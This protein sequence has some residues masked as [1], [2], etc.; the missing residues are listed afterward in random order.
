MAE[1]LEGINR[2]LKET[3][4]QAKAAANRIKELEANLTSL[5]NKYAKG[6][7]PTE[8]GI[9]KFQQRFEQTGNVPYRGRVGGGAYL[10][11]GAREEILPI[12]RELQ[13]LR[14][15]SSELTR[16]FQE[17]NK[18]INALTIGTVSKGTPELRQVTT[19][20]KDANKE[21]VLTPAEK[22]RRDAELQRANREA[23]LRFSQ[24]E[25]GISTSNKI[26]DIGTSARTAQQRIIEKAEKQVADAISKRAQQEQKQ[27]EEDLAAW[28]RVSDAR[29]AEEADIEAR[30]AKQNAVFQQYL[31]GL[32]KQA[33]QAAQRAQAKTDKEEERN[34]KKLADAIQKEADARAK[35]AQKVIE[36]AQEQE[37][38][39]T[40]IQQKNPQLYARASQLGFT[41]DKESF[42]V[43]TTVEGSTGI[44][45]TT[46][47]YKEL[48]GTIQKLTVTQNK[49]NKILN[50][51]QKR[52]RDLGSAIVRDIGEV[53]KWSIAV[54]AVYAP[55]QKV[56]ELTT[57]M[58]DNESKLADI[59]IILGRSH[60]Q[61]GEIFRNAAQAAAATGESING[62]IEGYTLAYRATGRYTNEI[63]RS[64]VAQKLL[65]D[66]LVLSKLSALD[67]AGAMDT[68][69]GALQQLGYNLD[70]GSELVN[71]WVTVSK[72]ANVG[73][74]TLAE[75]FA[76]TSTS[77]QN[78][79]LSI[80]ELNGIIAV[81]AENTTLSATEA[82]N[83]VRAFISGFQTD[84]ARNQLSK[85]GIAM[86]D[87]SGKARSFTDVMYQISDLYQAGV[88]S[89]SQLN[90]IGEAI[91]GGARRGAQVVATIKNLSR[92]QDIATASAN[93]TND[94]YDALG[95]KLQTLQSRFTL[96]GNSFQEL[97]QNLG[98]DGGILSILKL[99]VSV[100]DAAV[101]SLSAITKSAGGIAPL[102]FGGVGAYLYTRSTGALNPKSPGGGVY[103]SAYNF[104]GQNSALFQGAVSKGLTPDKFVSILNSS[105]TRTLTSVLA[106]L[107][108]LMVL[109]QRNRQGE[110]VANQTIGAI[111]GGIGGALITGL[112]PVGAAVGATIG[113][114]FVD[115]VI[116]YQTSFENFFVN[117]FD[118]ATKK[119]TE[120]VKT[121]LERE[122]EALTKE[123]FTVAGGGSEARG[124][125]IS[126][127]TAAVSNF[128]TSFGA[129]LTG[130]GAPTKI[131]PEIAALGLT[132]DVL[133]IQGNR[134]QREFMRRLQELL[135]RATL[136]KDPLGTGPEQQ[137]SPFSQLV[138]KEQQRNA[139]EITRL[140]DAQRNKLRE[141]AI[142]QSITSKE[143]QQGLDQL[144]SGGLDVI[145]VFTAMNDVL[146]ETQTS[147][148]GLSEV[149]FNAT[150]DQREYILQ[151]T[152]EI[153]DLENRIEDP[154]RLRKGE[155][156]AQLEQ[157][158]QDLTQQLN[159][160]V[161]GVQSQQQVNKIKIP[162]VLYFDKELSSRELEIV[163][164]LAKQIQ[165]RELKIAVEEGG[166]DPSVIDKWKQDVEPWFVYLEDRYQ[167]VTGVDQKYFQ[168]A[169]D[170]AEAAGQVSTTTTPFNITTID[171]YR[172]QFL[173]AYQ[174][175]AGFIKSAFP[176]YQFQDQEAQGV[177]FK[178][179][180][181]DVLHLDNLV[182]QLALQELIDVNKKQLDGLYNLPAGANFYVPIQTLQY[183]YNAG[184]NAGGGVGGG[185]FAGTG[186]SSNI[187]PTTEISDAVKQAAQDLRA[188]R[189]DQQVQQLMSEF[190]KAA[191]ELRTQ[192]SRERLNPKNIE[193]LKNVTTRPHADEKLSTTL[194]LDI[195]S[196]TQ[197]MLDGRIVANVIKAYLFEELIQLA[198]AAST[199]NRSL[200][201][202]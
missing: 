145:Q 168:R 153:A 74:D 56:Q 14:G 82:G 201:I 176:Q 38:R 138:V 146:G 87:A 83:A 43:Q 139:A 149:L 202:P 40:S 92:A 28:R 73:V 29:R 119:S 160:Y 61:M 164:N 130:K 64:R 2:Q 171:A 144:S 141:L 189:K 143:Y 173:A 33:Q 41:P 68:L 166:V 51:T 78:A 16:T 136:E 178:E 158:Q 12:L 58:I 122:Q 69:V 186:A 120:G 108:Q 184:L 15:R 46:L 85:F 44:K 187:K 48:D 35:A 72:V 188:E 94:A 163:I 9:S 126:Q 66:S 147:L 11:A 31:D 137:K 21:Y 181:T 107:P 161:Q 55:L 105:L 134:T 89:D 131:T 1:N 22:A 57:L 3:E 75:S 91:G 179:N 197:L 102:L 59:A 151:L 132:G 80:D 7:T 157:R 50:D 148:E 39:F 116:E 150:D 110:N 169:L 123:I 129:I 30:N 47:Q 194:K 111:V 142:S 100:A 162:A 34:R 99:I 117:I 180:V 45:R 6:G 26:A 54:A 27:L 154:R 90:Q 84:N 199:I 4:L 18:V 104:L 60:S 81:A 106:G 185:G 52:F 182:T 93:A 76:I 121:A 77:A 25:T 193:D 177:I 109:Y 32:D 175:A 196:T 174:K 49:Y 10:G 152:T 86:D 95:I 191:D 71:K 115:T 62:V 127:L 98:D 8:T 156:T 13:E 118:T 190:S 133:N 159:E 96:L 135:K 19:S 155:S 165:E 63:E 200:I 172:D 183:A 17:L 36:F 113:T 114:T 88:I 79:G 67:Q 198:G 140:V 195:T 124:K 20:T 170:V 23:S 167:K 103:G 24:R 70:Q 112:N 192:N 42:Q 53:F 97:A 101:K 125:A 65:I 37:S 5:I 128:A